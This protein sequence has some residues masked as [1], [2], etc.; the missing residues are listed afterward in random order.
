MPQSGLFFFPALVLG[1]RA[2]G[3]LLEISYVLR[4]CFVEEVRRV[5]E[6]SSVSADSVGRP[7]GV[8]G[9]ESKVF[10]RVGC[11][12]LRLSIRCF[13]ILYKVLLPSASGFG[14]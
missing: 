6:T 4:L 14:C 7:F 12:L 11:R 13:R 8:L 9:L 3:I 2:P 10:G 1:L 5:Q